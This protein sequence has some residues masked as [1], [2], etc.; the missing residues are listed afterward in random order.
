MAAFFQSHLH[1]TS[2]HG[3]A[4]ASR[5]HFRA[6]GHQ[7]ELALGHSRLRQ[8]FGRANVQLQLRHRVMHVMVVNESMHLAMDQGHCVGD[9]EVGVD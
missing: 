5:N 2:L 4:A 3:L 6:E 1:S 7:H 8:K 9:I